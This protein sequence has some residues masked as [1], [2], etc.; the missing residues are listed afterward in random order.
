MILRD[1]PAGTSCGA[2]LAIARRRGIHVGSEIP[3]RSG[4]RGTVVAINHTLDRARDAVFV[5]VCDDAAAET[6]FLSLGAAAYRDTLL[7]ESA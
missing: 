3:I 7:G 6:L 4:H 5:L 1:I 2:C